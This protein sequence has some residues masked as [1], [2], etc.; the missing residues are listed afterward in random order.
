MSR[1]CIP[2]ILINSEEAFVRAPR[3]LI[4]G[5]LALL[6]RSSCC[7]FRSGASTDCAPLLVPLV[8]GKDVLMFSTSSDHDLHRVRNSNTVCIS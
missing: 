5:S 4:H 8:R 3:P 1:L 2:L 7:V 6:T